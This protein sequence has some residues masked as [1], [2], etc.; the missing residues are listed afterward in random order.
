M[1]MRSPILRS[2]AL[3]ALL[4][5]GTLA[6]SACHDSV[7]PH[8][9]V[10]VTVQAA[11]MHGPYFGADSLGNPT[12]TCN[13]DFTASAAGAATAHWMD[14]TY[15]FYYGTTR[16]TPDA[17]YTIPEREIIQGWTTD[18]I[19]AAASQKSTW[20]F[21]GGIPFTGEFEFRYR[22]GTDTVTKHSTVRFDCGPA[23]SD[24]TPPPI[25]DT[26]TFA[27][28]SGILPAGAPL[29][30]SFQASSPVGLWESAVS[31]TGPC[32]YQ[33]LFLEQLHDSATH[34]L[35]I[36]MP[37]TCLHDVPIYVD[38]ITVDAAA[39][40]VRA[41]ITMPLVIEDRAPFGGG[42]LLAPS[43]APA[44]G[45]SALAAVGLTIARSPFRVGDARTGRPR[46]RPRGGG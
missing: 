19:V 9:E 3:V 42:S 39:Q 41:L 8:P 28:P 33:Q 11:A 44:P 13:V 5:A 20:I 34:E 27:P 10:N 29:T 38:V 15:R 23:V 45:A 17:V 4:A 26:I 24:S 46:A 40:G 25:I 2:E 1:P 14:A 16:R 35:S 18:T 36:P 21:Y 12:I 7:A 37:T 32:V 31:I 6:V 22:S 30:L 43:R